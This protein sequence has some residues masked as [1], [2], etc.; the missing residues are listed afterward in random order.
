MAQDQA[1][2]GFWV[3][4]VALVLD[5][6]IVFIILLAAML[7]M[8]ALVATVGMEGP[9]GW[10]ANLAAIFLPFLYWPALE[11][12]AWQA[13]VGKRIMGLQVTDTDGGR[14]SFVHALMRML[15]KIVSSIPFGLGFAMAAFT[16]RKQALH[17]LIVKTLVVRSGPSHLWKIVLALLVGLALLVASAAGLFYY[18]VMPMFKKTFGDTVLQASKAGPERK[19]IPAPAPAGRAPQ[20]RP[21][22][23]PAAPVPQVAAPTGK[24]GPDPEFDAVAG[25]PLAGLE[26]PNTTRAGPAILELSTKFPNQLWM[27]VYTPVPAL[28]DASLMPGPIVTVNRVLDAGGADYFDAGSTFETDDFFRRPS[29]SRASAP[30]PH[31]AGTRTVHLKPGLSEQAL[32]KVEGQVNYA[33][34]VDPKS[35]AIEAKDAGKPVSLHAASV[36]L[37]SLSGNSAKLH[38]RGASEHLLLVRGYG[39]DGKLLAVESRQILP[40]N[41]DVDQDYTITFKGPVAKVEFEVAARIIERFFPFSLVRG[42]VAGPP[43]AASSGFTLPARTSQAVAAAPATVA[44][45]AA[46]AP[47][48]SPPAVPAPAPAPA[49]VA[50]PSPKP[51][52]TPMAAAPAKPATKPRSEPKATPAPSAPAQPLG[53]AASQCVYKP[54]MTDED[55]ARCR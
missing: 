8:V 48:A 31:L 46:P 7:G 53:R 51:A 24:E 19:T 4:L 52:S 22:V 34:P 10:I 12:S 23:Q 33:V 18:V 47:V 49:P 36:S 16:A 37:V 2:G 20:P 43:P 44:P 1:Y 9:I 55:I 28:G 15:A 14:L 38:Y 45:A 11:S 29:L 6:A 35:T 32:Q 41:Q 39:A 13:T 50:A 17:D 21:Q 27:K 30:V 5:N 54:V 26:K 40:R 25:K 3:R 42:A